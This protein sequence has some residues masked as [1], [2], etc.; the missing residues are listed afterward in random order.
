MDPQDYSCQVSSLESHFCSVNCSSVLKSTVLD[1]K[2]TMANLQSNFII[3][4]PHKYFR[5]ICIIWSSLD[6][7]YSRNL[8]KSPKGQ[9]G[10]NKGFDWEREI[11]DFWPRKWSI[12][13]RN[14]LKSPISSFLPNDMIQNIANP[15]DLRNDLSHV[16]R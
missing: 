9:N 2:S 7:N 8:I 5:P 11:Y 3:F 15:L 4:Y 1:Q 13:L 10:Q 16:I 14:D 6:H 12:G